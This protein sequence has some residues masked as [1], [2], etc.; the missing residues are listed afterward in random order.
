M[1]IECGAFSP[2]EMYDVWSHIMH[3]LSNPSGRSVY[4]AFWQEDRS[5]YVGHTCI[6]ISIILVA[7][8]LLQ[9]V[10]EASTM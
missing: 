8:A 1:N 10:I 7:W 4:D 9:N 6:L 5:L 3:D 2:K